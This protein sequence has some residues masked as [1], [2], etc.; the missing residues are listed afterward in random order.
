MAKFCM[1]A[2]ATPA[3]R[4]EQGDLFTSISDHSSADVETDEV[5]IFNFRGAPVRV[6]TGLAPWFV[7]S[8]IAKALGYKDAASMIRRLDDHYKGMHKIHTPGGPQD[9]STISE[10]GIYAAI[11]RSNHAEARAFERWVTDEVLPSIRSTG[12]YMTPAAVREFLNTPQAMIR[13]LMNFEETQKK[14]KEAEAGRLYDAG[15]ICV[16]E[17]KA[18]LADDFLS[19]KGGIKV[20]QCAIQIKQALGVKCTFGQNKMFRWLRKHK[21]LTQENYPSQRASDAG[22]LVVKSGTHLNP[23]CGELVGHY[24]PMVTPKGAAHFLNLIRD[25]ITKTG[26]I[27]CD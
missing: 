5:R 22:Y 27:S 2:A 12:M 19:A 25:E 16:L 24:T 8:D 13:V 11:F 23:V 6:I 3:S 7:A 17:P 4:F 20:G 10:P 21:F 26:G 14:L 1:S 18:K 15:R 9:M